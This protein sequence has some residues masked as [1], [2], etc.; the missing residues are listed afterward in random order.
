MC[1][2]V[3]QTPAGI[4]SP[5]VCSWWIMSYNGPPHERHDTERIKIKMEAHRIIHL[6]CLHQATS[7]NLSFSVFD[8]Y[9]TH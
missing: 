5:R 7:R 2:L 9:K 8:I 6:E 3:H 1:K 4:L